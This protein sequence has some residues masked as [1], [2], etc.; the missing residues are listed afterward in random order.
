MNPLAFLLF[1]LIPIYGMAQA[2]PPEKV[3]YEEEEHLQGRPVTKEYLN[4]RGIFI[5]DK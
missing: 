5:E 1:T 3:V 4:E 2:V